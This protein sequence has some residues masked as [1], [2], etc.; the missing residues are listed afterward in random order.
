MTTKDDAGGPTERGPSEEQ[1]ERTLDSLE[2]PP[3]IFHPVGN[4][5]W[6][7]ARIVATAYRREK[8]AREAAEKVANEAKGFLESMKNI[9]QEWRMDWSDF[10]GRTLVGQ[11]RRTSLDLKNA[12]EAYDA[13]RAGGSK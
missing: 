2:K 9:A 4:Y 10:D 11:V 13:I 6:G 3:A 12:L 7:Q 8:A 5:W 1:I